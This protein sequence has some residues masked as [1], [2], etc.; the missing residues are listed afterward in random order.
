MF[1]VIPFFIVLLVSVFA[2]VIASKRGT[3]FYLADRSLKWPMLFGTLIGTQLG[4]GF[5]LGNADSS[6]RLG[7]WGCVYGFGIAIGL[8]FMGLSY[9]RRLCSSN[10]GTLP[11][12]LERKY[13]APLL[14]RVAGVLSIFSL[15][16]ILMC[17]AIGC[18]KYLL[19]LGFSSEWFFFA[20]WGVV[21]FYTTYGGLLA[22]V[23]TDL[24]QA[25]VMIAMLGAVFCSLFLPNWTKI[26]LQA[27]SLPTGFS[28]DVLI[29]LVIPMGFVFVEQ[30]MAQRCFAAKSPKD[31]TISCL[32]TALFL[33]LVSV[34]PFSAG[35]LGR[36]MGA[37]PDEGSVF[38]QVLQSSFSPLLFVVGS[39]AVLLAI[40]STASSVLLALSSNIAKDIT[41]ANGRLITGVLGLLS[42]LGPY[43]GDDII[44]WMVS[45][46]EISVVT[47]LV[48]LVMAVYS[49]RNNLP[50]EAAWGSILC[51]AIAS[52]ITRGVEL[53]YMRII[54]L[55]GSSIFGFAIGLYKGQ[56]RWSVLY[57]KKENV[58]ERI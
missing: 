35:L 4:G 53:E 29:S 46:Y 12:L 7:I 23:W 56:N 3:D 58:V 25:V 27:R 32:L 11:E 13:E 31:V 50:Q 19:S 26:V 24:F 21:I 43:F 51:G 42:L 45:S 28:P 1:S 30:D 9:G 22:V 2:S 14:R 15:S 8:M 16:G 34:V 57:R 54:V 41:R 52:A 48:P 55:F 20:C 5:I 38:I 17:L 18:K 49:T 37:S 10:M 47:L 44:S 33:V 40:I 36:T 6:W 39:T